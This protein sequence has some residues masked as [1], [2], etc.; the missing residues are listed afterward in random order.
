MASYGLRT[1]VRRKDLG[2]VSRSPKIDN[3]SKKT[4][5]QYT[6]IAHFVKKKAADTGVSATFAWGRAVPT[7]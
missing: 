1:S 6:N 3:V 2:R 4:G 7:S 5:H